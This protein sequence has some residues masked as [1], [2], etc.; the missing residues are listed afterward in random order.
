MFSSCIS[1]KQDVILKE[2][3]QIDQDLLSE[4]KYINYRHVI[5]SAKLPDNNFF[6]RG[7]DLH[8]VVLYYTV[9]IVIC[10]STYNMAYVAA[11]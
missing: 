8:S 6:K 7:L 2:H 11:I 4:T 3:C 5:I 10:C 9:F 1:T